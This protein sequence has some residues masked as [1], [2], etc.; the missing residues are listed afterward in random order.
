MFKQLKTNLKILQIK[1][2]LQLCE[3]LS[4]I[5]KKTK[6]IIKLPKNEDCLINFL[7]YEIN[8]AFHIRANK[9]SK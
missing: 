2:L 5:D 9:G 4:E 8:K 7:D 3:K 6:P 1:L